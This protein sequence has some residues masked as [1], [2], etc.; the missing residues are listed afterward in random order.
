MPGPTLVVMAAG[1][2]SRYGGLKQ[3]DPVGPSGEIIIDYSIYDA[4]RAGFTKV[5]F[6]I[7]RD[8]EQ[9]FR[10]KVGRNVES[11]METEYVFQEMADIPAPFEAPPGRK[12]PWGTGHAVLAARGAVSAPFGVI[13]ADDFYG[14]GAFELLAGF[15]AG[16]QDTGGVGD[17]CLVG[18]VLWNTLSDHGH[19]ARGVCGVA[20]DGCLT[21]IHE[22]THIRKF[23]EEVRYTEDGRSWTAVPRDSTA[24]MN[25]WGFT[26]GFLEKLAERFPA[27]LKESIAEPKAEFFVPEVVGAL[28]REGGARVRVLATG[29]RW[30]G[31]TYREDALAVKA[32][33]GGLVERGAYPRDLWGGA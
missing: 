24:S 5:V 4:L 10:E 32:A 20:P 29:E 3:I 21:E 8:I 19:V 31:V 17:Y 1:I 14:A 9:A 33:V 26:P 18:Y 11:R 23:G 28:V 6:V 13:N 30:L 7:R 15:L 2:G 22:R 25:I 16:A 12:K 27:F